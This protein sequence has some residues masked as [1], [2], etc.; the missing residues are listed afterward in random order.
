[1][2]VWA[3]AQ[4]YGWAPFSRD[5]QKGIE[6]IVMYRLNGIGNW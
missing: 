4:S 1:L 5:T 2:I 3:L 6:Y